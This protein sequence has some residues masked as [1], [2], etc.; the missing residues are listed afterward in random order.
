MLAARPDD[1]ARS[2]LL[3][4]GGRTLAVET[5]WA[6]DGRQKRAVGAAILS[7]VTHLTQRRSEHPRG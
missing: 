3:L 5:D 7:N 2:E 6:E 1:Q 4:A